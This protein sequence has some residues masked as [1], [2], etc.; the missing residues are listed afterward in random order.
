[1]AD[2]SALKRAFADYARTIARRYDIGEVLYRLTDQVVEVFAIDGAGVSLADVDGNLQFVTA[3]DERVTLVEEQQVE[4]GQGPCHDAYRSGDRVTVADLST[5]ARWADYT[6]VALGKGL[7]AAAGIPLLSGDQRVGALNLYTCQPREW[8]ADDMEDAQLLADMATGYIINARTLT[9]T[10]RLASQLQH[11]LDSRVVIEQA[12]GIL[13][14]RH[15]IN[16]AT[17]FER[18]RRHARARNAKIHDVARAVLRSDL[19]V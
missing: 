16:T 3:T 1:M 15:S 5:E 8:P 6:P 2:Q 4:T 9:E 19:D 10:E 18:L 12:K 13:A 7:R 11:A 14:E 17:A